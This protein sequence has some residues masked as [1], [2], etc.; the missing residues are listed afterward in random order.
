MQRLFPWSLL[1]VCLIGLSGLVSVHAHDQPKKAGA[2]EPGFQSIFN[3]KDLTGWEGNLEL[4]KVRDGMIVGDSPG[5]RQNEFLATKKQYGDF[6]LR[7]EFKLHGGSGNSGV[8][9]RTR[10][11][12]ES[13]EVE[14]YQADIG[15]NYWGCLYDE[16]RRRKVLAQA[17]PELKDVLKKDDWNEYVIRAQGNHIVLKINGVTTVDYHEK[18]PQIARSGIIAVQVHSG[19]PLRVDFRKLRICE[20]NKNN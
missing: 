18:D 3:G 15:E 10:R 5:I 12:P 13:S 14:G 20:L 19:P 2:T 1:C 16:H 6:E 9:F 17:A 4:W 11:V 7:L 8:Q